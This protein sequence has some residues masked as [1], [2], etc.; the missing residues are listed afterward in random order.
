MV[1]C[2]ISAAKSTPDWRRPGPLPENSLMCGIFGFIDERGMV[3]G[4]RAVHDF[5]HALRHRGPDSYGYG[6]DDGVLIGMV[7][8]AIVDVEGGR[9]PF[10]SEQGDVVAVVNG[11]IYNYATLKSE[12]IAR[13]HRFATNSDC[14][15]VVHLYEEYGESF[16]EHVEGMYAI[17]V[18]DRGRQRLSLY[19]D[20]FGKKPIY[21]RDNGLFAFSSEIK[22]LLA[23]DGAPRSLNLRSL[24]NFLAFR[25][26]LGDET[27]FEGIHKLPQGGCLIY[28]RE[29]GELSVRRYWSPEYHEI[30]NYDEDFAAE[31]ILELF[32]GAVRKRL[33]SDVPIGV[34]LSGGIDSSAIVAVMAEMASAPIRTFTLAYEDDFP[35]K[36][37]DTEAARRIA[38]EYGCEHVE[39]VMSHRELLSDMDD[40]LAA[41]DEPFGMG[42]STYFVCKTVKQAGIRVLMNGDGGDEHFGSYRAHRLAIPIHNLMALR[43]G[44]LPIDECNL[45]LLRPCEHLVDELERLAAPDLRWR[46]KLFPITP[47]M[48]GELLADDVADTMAG[49]NPFDWY[50]ATFLDT[51]TT[52]DPLNRVLQL[53][54][55]TFLA[56]NLLYL[57]DRLSMAHSIEMRCPF[58]DRN[59]TQFLNTLP[60]ALRMK[61]GVTKYIQ[62][63]AFERI[64]PG[65]IV[66]RPKE[67][68]ILPTSE[69]LKGPLRERAYETLS[70]A[71]LGR[72]GFFQPGTVRRWLDEHFTGQHDHGY[73]IWNLMVFQYWYQAN[74]SEVASGRQPLSR[75]APAEVCVP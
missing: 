62:K 16:I 2:T 63:K 58:L 25:Y 73:L 32:R 34:L 35:G 41:F 15:V 6:L 72:H 14:E 66:H 61:G 75:V 36:Q 53:E 64:L 50:A 54:I 46:L 22:G 5:I 49:Y 24:A 51:G 8:L 13:G 3:D 44:G 47:D 38:R 27:I 69:W 19:R 68:F 71:E 60:G 57:S 43:A 7:R 67:G 10:Y 17:A 20:R 26:V 4:M 1:G 39:H 31:R 74:A 56:D 28:D 55:N 11:E 52:A 33:I 18:Y 48:L 30:H 9:Q 40:V 23:L 12:L 29:T 70:E 45:H 21:Y 65:D 37:A 59:L 42:L